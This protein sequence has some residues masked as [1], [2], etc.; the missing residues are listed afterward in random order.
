MPTHA[1]WERF[2]WFKWVQTLVFL[3]HN[4]LE[5]RFRNSLFCFK[6]HVYYL[7]SRQSRRWYFNSLD[8]SWQ[9]YKMK[10]ITLPHILVKI[11]LV[12]R[13]K[14]LKRLLVYIW[15]SININSHLFSFLVSLSVNLSMV[16]LTDTMCLQSS[17][18]QEFLDQDVGP[19]GIIAN[20]QPVIHLEAW[21][22]LHGLSPGITYGLSRISSWGPQKKQS[23][24]SHSGSIKFIWEF[25]Y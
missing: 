11:K 16:R 8:L 1:F 20:I 23:P 17:K 12:N 14:A 21:P 19:A 22:P 7:L 15:D 6:F 4:V 3:E 24:V 9:N 10:K 13:Y 5:Y 25:P 2:N 18:S